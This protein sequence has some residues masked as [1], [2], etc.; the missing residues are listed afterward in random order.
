MAAPTQKPELLVIVG[1]TASGKSELALRIAKRFN[2]EI[3]A[4]DSWTVYRG[5]DI[6]TAKPT[7]AEQKAVKHHLVDVTDAKS[8]FNA[9]KFKKLAE[10]ALSDIKKRGKLPILAGGTGLYIDSVIFD[11][12][13]L[14][15]GTP[16]ERERLNELNIEEL[17]HEAENKKVDLTGVDI[18]NKRRIIRAIE[19]GGRQPTKND[20]KQGVLM[21]GI[22]V[23]GEELKQKVEQRVEKMFKQ[24]LE[25]EVKHLSKLY[26]WDN[27]PMKGIG[28]KEWKDYF[29]GK[30]SLEQTKRRIVSATMNLAKRQ[31][32]WFKRNSH[33]RWFKTSEGAYNYLAKLA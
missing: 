6:G 22:R 1:P 27:E 21:V 20:L 4:A 16:G 25:E 23:P 17:L 13:F 28:Y 2:G 10:K 9:P 8:G 30:Q 14:P 5:F 11:Y 3:I 15:S 7:V 32:T 12:S 33:I 24:G 18:R 29:E 19:S 26:G 31:R